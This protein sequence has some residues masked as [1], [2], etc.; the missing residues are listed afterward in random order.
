MSLSR[1][2]PKS[3]VHRGYLGP[4]PPEVWEVVRQAWEVGIYVSSDG[5]RV[6]APY[7]ALAA[8]IGWISNVSLDGLSFNRVWNVTAEGVAALG[9]KENYPSC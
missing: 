6:L 8:S 3:H 4:I 1:S 2:R 7:V 9:H 5:A